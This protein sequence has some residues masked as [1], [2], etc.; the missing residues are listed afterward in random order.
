MNFNDF[1][2]ED[3]L[4]SIEAEVAKSTNEIRHAQDDLDK[5]TNRLKFALA[6]LHFVRD[7]YKGER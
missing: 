1:N 4:K 7:R 2:N 6:V 3:L 5:A